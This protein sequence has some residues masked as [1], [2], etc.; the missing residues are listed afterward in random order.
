VCDDISGPDGKRAASLRW[1]EVFTT[2]H[3]GS[4]RYFIANELNGAFMQNHE[5]PPNEIDSQQIVAGVKLRRVVTF[6]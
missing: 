6:D 4:S 2:I 5:A 3:M 1:G